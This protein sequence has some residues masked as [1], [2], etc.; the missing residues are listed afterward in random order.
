MGAPKAA[1]RIGGATF[2]ARV[3]DG[4]AAALLDPILVVVGAHRESV[5]EALPGHDHV[6]VVVNRAPERGQ[7]SSLKVGLEEL[8]MTAPNVA[9]VVVALVDH[10]MVTRATVAALVHAARED[11]API[12]VPSYAGRRG[13]PIVFMRPVW[14]ELL[15]TPDSDS[16]RAV[17]RRDATRVRE[18][19]VDDLG[20]VR[21]FDT[22]EDLM[23]AP[24][25]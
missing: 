17:V 14:A 19:P 12:I 11:P 25:G 21:D 22:P 9:G 10:A 2:I 16:A 24:H 3:I 18:V 6:R 13:H 23:V 5:T 15:A 7:L 8:L 4:L 20:V 1:L